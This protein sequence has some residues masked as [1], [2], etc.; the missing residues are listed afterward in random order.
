MLAYIYIYIYRCIYMYMVFFH[1]TMCESMCD[2][3]SSSADN[4]GCSVL[5]LL[6]LLSSFCHRTGYSKE[7]YIYVCVCMYMPDQLKAE[8]TLSV[9][10]HFSAVCDL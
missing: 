3:L 1:H 2:T 10:L 7:I 6:V 9:H 8:I 5:P 4:Q